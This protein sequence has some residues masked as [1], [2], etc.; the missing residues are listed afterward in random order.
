MFLGCVSWSWSGVQRQP[1]LG[2]VVPGAGRGGGRAGRRVPRRHAQGLPVRE[3]R[4]RGE[5]E[6]DDDGDGVVEKHDDNGGGCRSYN[7]G[8]E[9]YSGPSRVTVISS[10]SILC[11]PPY[12]PLTRWH[13]CVHVCRYLDRTQ[14]R[15]NEVDAEYWYRHISKGGWPFSTAAHGWPIA[16]CTAEGRALSPRGCTPD[17]LVLHTEAWY[18]WTVRG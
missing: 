17:D 15:D 11:P 7:N 2:H 13:P 3:P 16:D 10:G 6:D 4:G 9:A 5:E 8:T 1:V 14:I 12:Q 18:Q